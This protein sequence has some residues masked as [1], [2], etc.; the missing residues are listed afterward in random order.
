MHW[1][2]LAL[3]YSTL[4]QIFRRFVSMVTVTTVIRTGA[5]VNRHKAVVNL[6]TFIAYFPCKLSKTTANHTFYI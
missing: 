1:P 6:R 3:T 2:L 4:G 5:V